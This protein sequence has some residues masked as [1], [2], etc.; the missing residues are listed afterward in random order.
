MADI[1]NTPSIEER[2]KEV[3][4]TIVSLQ[5][6]MAVAERNLEEGKKNLVSL[7]LR[8]NELNLLRKLRDGELTLIESKTGEIVNLNFIKQA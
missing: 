4:N 2:I 8:R 3:E 6:T 5:E 1:H 7:I